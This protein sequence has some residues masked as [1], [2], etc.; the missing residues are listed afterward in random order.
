MNNPVIQQTLVELEDNL[1][2]L[3]SAR[4]Q[5][6]NVVEKS[7]QVIT[8]FKSILKSVE[9]I[10]E[11]IGID[12]KSIED[13]LNNSFKTF[14]IELNKLLVKTNDSYKSV[15]DQ[16]EVNQQK[17]LK[18]VEDNID[19]LNESFKTINLELQNNSHETNLE[20][21]KLQKEFEDKLLKLN[22]HIS[23]LEETILTTEQKIKDL[24][25]KEE[26]DL[27]NNKIEKL[28]KTNQYVFGIGCF[29][30]LLTILIF[31]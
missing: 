23:N 17:F 12:K 9:S 14:D 29:I 10:N 7:E 22:Q 11:G 2:K 1:L 5:V 24:N 30:I 19:N 31:R 21:N 3:E 18:S 6:N 16:N 25:F 15:S 27:L 4:T 28:N 8:S 20:L 26:F 13:I